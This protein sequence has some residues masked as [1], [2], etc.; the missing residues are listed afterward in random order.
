MVQEIRELSDFQNKISTAGTVV[1]DF[2]S[3]FCGPCAQIAP[4]IDALATVYDNVKFY[5]VDVDEASDIA[6][7]NNISAMPTFHFYKNRQLMGKVIGAN[8][9]AIKRKLNDLVNM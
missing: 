7:E 8:L 2:F 6:E 1:V 3:Q 4:K 9:G 5:K